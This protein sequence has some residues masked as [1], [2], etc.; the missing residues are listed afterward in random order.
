MVRRVAFFN[1]IWNHA[2]FCAIAYLLLESLLSVDFQPTAWVLRGGIRAYQKVASAHVP[3][4]CKFQPTCSHYGLEAV[5]KYGTLRGSALTAWRI[6][7][8][9]PFSDGG[10]DPVP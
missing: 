8:C 3:T 5:R 6:L 2:W 10:E 7:R 9:N 1:W 4:I